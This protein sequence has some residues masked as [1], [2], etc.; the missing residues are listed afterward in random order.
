M[1]KKTFNLYIQPLDS[2]RNPKAIAVNKIT[3]EQMVAGYPLLQ[4]LEQFEYYCNSSEKFILAA[5]GSYFDVPFLKKQYE[6]INRKWPFGYNSLDLKSIAIW[7]MSKRDKPLSG[8]LKKFLNSL[9]MEFKGT[10]HN[11]LDDIT[12]TANLLKKFLHEKQKEIK[13]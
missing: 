11:A 1:D 13:G 3:E 12:N 2:Y 9:N 10:P 4:A 6:K 5:W 7:E 8:G